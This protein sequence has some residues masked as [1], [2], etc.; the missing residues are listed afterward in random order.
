MVFFYY[1]KWSKKT[2]KVTQKLDQVAIL[3]K[4]ILTM[5]ILTSGFFN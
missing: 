3:D 2:P 1:G 4:S 5:S